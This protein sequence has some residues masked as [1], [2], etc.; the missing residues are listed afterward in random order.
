MGRAAL[1]TGSEKKTTSKSSGNKYCGGL[2]V[3]ESEKG[4]QILSFIV[5]SPEDKQ[6]L[7][8]HLTESI[9][10]GESFMLRGIENSYKDSPSKPNYVFMIPTPQEEQPKPKGK[11]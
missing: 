6:K 3:K 1:N 5:K 9:E 8:D 2:W 11:L 7:L 10:S 4:N